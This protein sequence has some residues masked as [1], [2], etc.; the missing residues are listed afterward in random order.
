MYIKQG[1]EYTDEEVEAEYK[2]DNCDYSFDLW[3]EIEGYNK[4]PEFIDK[5][6]EQLG[7][8]KS[9]EIMLFLCAIFFGTYLF[10]KIVIE[11]VKYIL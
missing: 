3:I 8:S 10:W 1:K 4:I 6:V 2:K 11:I 5:R 9:L 7:T